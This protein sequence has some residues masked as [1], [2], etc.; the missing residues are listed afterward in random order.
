AA[1][2]ARTLH[3]GSPGSVSGTSGTLDPQGRTRRT[4]APGTACTLRRIPSPAGNASAPT[5]VKLVVSIHAARPGGGR[6]R[7]A[8]WAVTTVRLESGPA[9][10]A[11]RNGATVSSGSGTQ[12]IQPPS[13]STGTDWPLTPR[14][15]GPRAPY[16]AP[17]RNA[18]SCDCSTSVGAG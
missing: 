9:V 10:A 6:K 4:D 8:M 14:C 12:A 1:T 5:G 13:G 17:K 11:S 15:T 16:T 7:G 3:A 2:N 18:E